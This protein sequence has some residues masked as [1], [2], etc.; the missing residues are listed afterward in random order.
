MNYALLSRLAIAVIALGASGLTHAASALHGFDATYEV[1][2]GD[3]VIGQS[4][5]T[6]ERQADGSWQYHSAMK[7]TA[8][9]AS[10]LGASVDE[11]SRF[12]WQDNAPEALSYDYDLHL[13]LKSKSRHLK[14]DWQNKQVTV[15]T[16]KGDHHYTAVPGLV[17]RHTVPLAIAL[18]LADGKKNLNLPVAVKDRV[19]VQRYQVTGTQQVQVPAGQ[20]HAERVDRTD[21]SKSFS[22]WFVPQKFLVPVKLAQSDGGDITLLLKSYSAR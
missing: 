10:L 2:R 17:E 1:Q 21:D 13:S 7:G 8:G 4:T 19:Q 16:K 14:V 22:A 12:R 5:L 11:R 15:A 20:F 3:A 18:A 9:L 6:L